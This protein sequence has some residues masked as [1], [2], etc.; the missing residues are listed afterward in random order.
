MKVKMLVS[1]TGTIDG[2][3]WPVRGSEIELADHV[4]ADLIAN[5]YAETSATGEARTVKVET[6]AV[7]PIVETATK[8][9]PKARKKSVE[10]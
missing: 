3:P 7:D 5:G 2:Q 8:A 6:A 9:A 1:I 10:D 4:A